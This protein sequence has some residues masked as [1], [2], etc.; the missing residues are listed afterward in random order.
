MRQEQAC[1]AL[2]DW[3]LWMNPF[4]PWPNRTR[5]L[6][7]YISCLNRRSSNPATNCMG[8]GIADIVSGLPIDYEPTI[9][10]VE[11]T[12]KASLSEASASS[13]SGFS[14]QVN[15]RDENLENAYQLQQ[16]FYNQIVI[17]FFI[18]FI[19]LSLLVHRAQH[20]CRYPGAG[21]W[22]QPAAPAGCAGLYH[23]AALGCS[24]SVL[25]QLDQQS[26]GRT[27]SSG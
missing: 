16:D 4:L 17:V 27:R 15:S 9:E 23:P 6:P 1:R 2:W 3:P 20:C 10:A 11:T 14:L 8:L 25:L 12:A 22:P 26:S 19:L 18:I 7:N 5:V 21:L 24:S 13:T